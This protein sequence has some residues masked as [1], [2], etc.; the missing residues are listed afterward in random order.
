VHINEPFATTEEITYFLKYDSLYGKFNGDI[1]VVNE[2]SIEIVTNNQQFLT[3]VSHYDN[4]SELLAGVQRADYYIDASG[5]TS[6]YNIY[7][8]HGVKCVFTCCLNNESNEIIDTVNDSELYSTSGVFSASICDAVAIAPVLKAIYSC[9]E[10]NSTIIT[11]M[12]PALGYQ[13]VIDNY[14]GRGINK[15]LGRQYIDSIIPK[16]TSVEEVLKKFFPNQTI[17][18]MSF[19]IPTES[20]CV[21]DIAIHSNATIDMQKIVEE[22]RKNNGLEFSTED[23]VSIDFK[24]NQASACVDMRWTEVVDDHILK[25]IIWYDNEFGYS[26]HLLNLVEKWGNIN[27]M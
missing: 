1:H 24:G 8:Q 16:R 21:A 23:L 7:K 6:Y 14:P 2:H 27:E 13:K 12:H 17:R 15:S 11:T 19:R 25:L 3:T 20:V 26:A 10:V 9:T 5:N 4:V 22:L 18:C